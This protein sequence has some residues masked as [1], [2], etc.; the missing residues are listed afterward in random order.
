MSVLVFDVETTGLNKE[1][2]QI[3]ELAVQFGLHE[4]AE[5]QSW[6]FRPS[7]PIH[8]AAQA[9]HGLSAEMLAGEPPFSAMAAQLHQLFSGAQVLIGY[10]VGFDIE[11]LAAELRRAQL[12][13]IDFGKKTVVDALRLWQV[14]EP[15]QLQHAYGRFVGGSFAGAHSAAADVAATAQV[16]KGMLR[17]FNLEG[18]SLPEVAGLCEP[19]RPNW[20]GPS[21]HFHW[22]AGVAV[23]AFGKHSGKALHEMAAGPDRGYFEWMMGRDFPAHVKEICQAALKLEGQAFLASVARSYPPPGSPGAAAQR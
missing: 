11:M 7:V 5:R 12:P 1:T 20:I 10:N 15:R 8:P 2:D 3:I 18:Q 14:M 4:G 9:A 21:G 13:A 22:K 17:A 23:V 16:L 19:D 6:R